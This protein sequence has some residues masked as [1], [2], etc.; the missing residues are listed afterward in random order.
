M[1]RRAE[2][3]PSLEPYVKRT[4]EQAVR[5]ATIRAIGR[6]GRDAKVRADDMTWGISFA[7]ESAEVAIHGIRSHLCENELQAKARMVQHALEEI[8]PRKPEATRSDLYRRI[9]GR[10]DPRDI[11]RITEMLREQRFLNLRNIP[12]AEKG[13]RPK[14]IYTKAGKSKGKQP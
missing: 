12:P 9:D 2:K 10:L 7:V 4:A 1:T 5:L 14:T 8:W 11:D 6:D 13:G 3:A